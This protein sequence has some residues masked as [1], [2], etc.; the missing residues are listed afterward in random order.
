MKAISTEFW[1]QVSLPADIAPRIPSKLT[2]SKENTMSIVDVTLDC[3]ILPLDGYTASPAT[4]GKVY[5]YKFSGGSD[6]NGNVTEYTDDGSGIGTIRVTLTGSPYEIV[7]VSFNGDSHS[8]MSWIPGPANS[9]VIIKDTNIDNENVYFSVLAKDPQA[10]C[11]FGCDP[12][13]VNKPKPT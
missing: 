5:Y 11:T 2:Q 13:I 1:K 10:N 12:S 4:N 6:G 9:I 7:Q 8:D 3:T